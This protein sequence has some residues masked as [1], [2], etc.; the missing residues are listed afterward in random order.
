MIKD[1]L[2]FLTE[3]RDYQ[4]KT[5]REALNR[6]KYGIFHPP[7]S[8]KT[9]TAIDIAVNKFATFQV[10]NAIVCCPPNLIQS[11]RKQIELHC[12]E[13]YRKN[14]SI[15]SHM[16]FS[17][18]KFDMKKHRLNDVLIIDESHNFKN[19]TSKRHKNL[20]KSLDNFSQIISM[21]GT[22]RSK[23]VGD[24][25]FQL[26]AV[27]DYPGKKSNFIFEFTEWRPNPHNPYSKIIVGERNLD[28]LMKWFEGCS[29]WLKEE[30]IGSLPDKV[31][32]KKY[33][34]LDGAQKKLIKK[35][36]EGGLFVDDREERAMIKSVSIVNQIQSGFIYT[37]T[38]LGERVPE[39]LTPNPKLSLLL[40][41]LGE[42][43]AE[44]ALILC[45]FRHELD[46]IK[47]AI[48]A[49]YPELG[50]CVYHGGLSHEEKEAALNEFASKNCQIFI[51]TTRP[52]R[53]GLNEL[54]IANHIIYYSNS[55][56][57]LDRVQSEAR[58]RRLG[59]TKTAYY[60]DLICAESFDEFLLQKLEMRNFK[61]RELFDFFR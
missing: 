23:N 2:I 42:L 58:I 21:T 59:S 35:L 32:I 8:G 9:K 38:L 60:Y 40:D 55:P 6:A 45:S 49:N 25:Y 19:D 36:K 17:L 14:F 46:G 51:A 24:L 29:S 57:L 44:K 12:P 11:W 22:P 37:K 31:Y 33:Y 15:I 5:I 43:E 50:V 52:V 56:D 3:P 18:K 16:E 53:E 7:G 28:I 26:K 54:M 48:H 39:R 34:E 13:E 1:D 20:M 30:D 41:V 47:A 61:L 4:L 10:V 27:T